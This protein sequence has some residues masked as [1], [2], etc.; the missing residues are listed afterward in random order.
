MAKTVADQF[1]ETLSTECTKRIYEIVSDNLN[2]FTDTLRRYS[3]SKWVHLQHEEVPGFATGVERSLTD[4]LAV[5]AGSCGP[6][7]LHLINGLF[8]CNRSGAP[9]RP[10]AAQ[11]PSAEVGTGYFQ[12]TDPKALFQ[13]CRHYCELTSTASL[14]A[15]KKLKFAATAVAAGIAGFRTEDPSDVQNDG[16]A[17][18]IA[19]DGPPLTDAAVIDKS[20]PCRQPS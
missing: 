7:N 12:Q 13:E 3:K 2:G 6:G 11:I 17:A 20:L 16:I 4:Q 9:R 5:H 10:T 1:T 18:A 19:H 8:D 14:G 15:F